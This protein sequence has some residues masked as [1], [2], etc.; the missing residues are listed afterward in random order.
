MPGKAI[1]E[2]KVLVLRTCLF[3]GFHHDNQD[4]GTGG[5][6][7][8]NILIVEVVARIRMQLCRTGV[9]VTYLQVLPAVDAER[10]A[11]GGH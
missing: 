11:A 6:V 10:E 2:F 3:S 5:V 4:V 1:D 7:V 9:Q 8:G